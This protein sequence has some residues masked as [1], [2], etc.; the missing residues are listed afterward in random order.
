M[1]I[2]NTINGNKLFLKSLELNNISI[3][4]LNWLRDKEV[5]YYLETKHEKQSLSKIRSFV[6][7][8]NKSKDTYLLG[9]F[10]I[11]GVHIGNIK[12]GPIKFIHKLSPI[13]IFI[14]EKDYWG[15]GLAADAINT[16]SNFAFIEIG[17]NKLI[18]GM[19]SENTTSIKSFEKV[20]FVKEGIRKRHYKL[21]NVYTDIIELGLLRERY[22]YKIN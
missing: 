4:Y 2:T 14:G 22:N 1:K 6:S 13:S 10:T 5:N 11:D 9:I 17:L 15:K 16:L 12:L 19:Y 20:G 3:H 7:T 8:C 18:A 21:D